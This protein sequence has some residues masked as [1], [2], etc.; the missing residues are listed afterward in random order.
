M[1][2]GGRLIQTL[3][4]ASYLVTIY[5]L[6]DT[7]VMKTNSSMLIR[8]QNL[9][10]IKIKSVFSFESVIFL[11]KSLHGLIHMVLQRETWCE[12]LIFKLTLKK[13]H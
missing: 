9:A 13:S 10:D 7:T 1:I 12:I 11:K 8:Y 2:Q 4:S 5:I 6:N 3:K